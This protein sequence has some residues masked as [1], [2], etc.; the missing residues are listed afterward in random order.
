MVRRSDPHSRETFCR[1]EP[2]PIHPLSDYLKHHASCTY[3]EVIELRKHHFPRV[4]AVVQTAPDIFQCRQHPP[5]LVRRHA[6]LCYQLLSTLHQCQVVHVTGYDLRLKQDP[7][8]GSRHVTECQGTS[9]LWLQTYSYSGCLQIQP[10]QLA[11]DFQ[12]TFFKNSRR[13]FNVTHAHTHTHRDHQTSFIN[14]LLLL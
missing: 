11:G 5:Y 13:F 4:P 7:N 1:L 10:N 3:F 9:T 2:K 6:Q 8:A 14:F 12:D